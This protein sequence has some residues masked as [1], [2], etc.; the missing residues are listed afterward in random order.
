MIGRVLGPYQIVAK[1]GEGGM[2]EVYRARDTRLGRD[3]AIKILPASFAA[4]PDRRARFER[5]A[6]AVATLSHPNVIAIFDTGAHETTPGSGETQLF[7]VMELLAGQTLRERIDDGPLPVRKAVDIAV[8]IAFVQRLHDVGDALLVALMAL[9]K[10]LGR[11]LF[12]NARHIGPIQEAIVVGHDTI[13]T[14]QLGI[15]FVTLAPTARARAR[16][17]KP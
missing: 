8:Q 17:S 7:I 4:D 6:Q 2:G 9:P 3:V 15:V 13:R 1:V 12:G 14:N 5:E 11:N 16:R 10:F